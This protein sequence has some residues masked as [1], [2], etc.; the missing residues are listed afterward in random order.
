MSVKR[1]R[2][3]LGGGLI[4]GAVLIPT[5]AQAQE[6][7]RL[8]LSL[9]TSVFRY[10][11]SKTEYDAPVPIDPFEF[12]AWRAGVSGPG[13][14][15]G[16][17]YQ[18]SHLL[19]GLRS[20]FSTEHF[21]PSSA[22]AIHVSQSNSQLTL[23]PRVEYLIGRGE[24]RPFIA[25]MVGYTHTWGSGRYD[26]PVASNSSKS[27]S[28]SDGLTLGVAC[29]LHAFL[30]RWFSI[31]PEVALLASSAKGKQHSSRPNFDDAGYVGTVTETSTSSTKD[32]AIMVNVGL[33][34][35]LGGES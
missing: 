14:G 8:Q 30:N 9:Q 20:S 1:W 6:K 28:T 23:V 25:G 2:G 11:H 4:L 12:T 13:L 32:L 17:G 10:E 5:A 29:G 18:W 24:L 35:W 16:V 15:A 7:G 27:D 22:Y 19:V 34:G 33:S 26:M 3:I 21:T 31:D